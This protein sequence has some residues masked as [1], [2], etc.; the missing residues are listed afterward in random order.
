MSIHF[1]LNNIRKI[2]VI[3]ATGMLGKPVTLQL[4]AA[5]FEVTA[6]VRD[7]A[8]ASKVLPPTVKWVPADLKD[9]GSLKLALA[10]QD[11][12]YLNL[13][14]EQ[15]EGQSAF[16][17][18]GEGLHNALA[19]ARA[20]RLLRVSYLSSI[21]IRH[22]TDWWVFALKRRAV[23]DVMAS[24][25][26]YTIFYPT[27]FMETIDGRTMAGNRLLVV[28]RAQH[29]N[30][31]IAAAD[32]GRQVAND[33]K[34]DS[35]APRE[36]VVQGPEPILTGEAAE[37]F[38]KA[39]KKKPVA[40]TKLP[41]G[42]FKLLRSLSPRFRYGY[43]IINALNCYPE[44]FEAQNTWQDLGKPVIKLEDYARSL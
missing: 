18:E 10:G 25:L 29:P 34:N 40:V 4:A 12:L 28:G 14:V 21:V 33:F 2:A 3:G 30:W 42:P 44:T 37:R 24:G 22:P 9:A 36:Y 7:P 15:A 13:S 16:H 27:Q 17:P 26:P 35:P 31:W 23:E 5:G 41:M 32:Y 11:A 1:P 38:V 6:L 19:A 43:E 39:Y 20:N 8:K